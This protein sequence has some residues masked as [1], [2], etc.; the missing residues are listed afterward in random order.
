MNLFR[1]RHVP[2]ILLL[3]ALAGCTQQQNTQELKGK[4]K[5]KHKNKG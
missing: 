3:A 4:C 2:I 5:S 1:Y